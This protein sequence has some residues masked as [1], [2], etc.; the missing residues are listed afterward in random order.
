MTKEDL[1][2]LVADMM[3]KADIV[4]QIGMTNAPYPHEIEKRV[5]LDILRRSALAEARKAREAYE[6]ALDEYT[7]PRPPFDPRNVVKFQRF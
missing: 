1:M 2:M 6:R 4:M 7:N 5:E 3:A